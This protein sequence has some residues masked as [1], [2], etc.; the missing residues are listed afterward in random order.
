MQ[1]SI[2]DGYKAMPGPV[3][4]ASKFKDLKCHQIL[5][6]VTLPSGLQASSELGLLEI[7]SVYSSKIFSLWLTFIMCHNS[8]LASHFGQKLISSPYGNP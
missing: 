7:F 2:Q 6:V 5:V 3:R 1:A 4:K 8:N